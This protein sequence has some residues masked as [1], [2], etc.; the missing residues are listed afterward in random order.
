VAE[1]P[2]HFV[3]RKFERCVPLGGEPLILPHRD[4]KTGD[5]AGQHRHRKRHQHIGGQ[6]RGCPA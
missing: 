6:V 4:R 2:A 5:G 1:H 3:E